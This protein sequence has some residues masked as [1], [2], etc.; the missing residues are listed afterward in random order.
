MLALLGFKGENVSI[1]TGTIME[2][3][4]RKVEVTLPDEG[5]TYKIAKLKYAQMKKVGRAADG[6][7]KNDISLLSGLENGGNPKDQEW[8]DNLSAD[9]VLAL[10]NAMGDLSDI[11]VPLETWLEDKH[12]EIFREYNEEMLR[13]GGR[14]GSNPL[15]D[16]SG[17]MTP[18]VSTV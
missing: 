16:S 1:D 15:S 13:L 18:S 7:D 14:E 8:L 2:D 10:G 3:G 5:G 6:W 12:P 4:K 17:R 9:D 11:R